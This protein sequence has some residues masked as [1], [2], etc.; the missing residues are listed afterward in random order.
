MPFTAFQRVFIKVITLATLQFSQV[1]AGGPRYDEGLQAYSTGDIATAYQLWKPLAEHGD[2]DAQFAFGTLYYEGI[3]V[4]VDHTESSYWFH[5]AAE[6][7]HA[8]AQYNLG[9]AYKRG[10]GV[11]QND[12]MAIYWWEKASRQGVSEAQSNLATAYQEGAGVAHGELATTHTPENPDDNS[13]LPAPGMHAKPDTS[14]QSGGDANCESWLVR[15]PPAAYTIQLMSTRNPSDA[16]ELARRQ[17][18][19][20]YVVCRYAHEGRIRHALILGAYP[21]FDAAKKG[22][23]KL[24]PDLKNGKPWIRKIH[25]LKKLVENSAL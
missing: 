16:Y 9:N 13:R 25:S 5:L 6:Q 8:S 17:D 2:A 23:A 12:K 22:V 7:G 11:R 20:G 19:E 4:P 14:K 10:E 18:L 24:P 3:G 15:Q 21:S 1:H